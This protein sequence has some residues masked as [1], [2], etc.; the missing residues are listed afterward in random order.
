MDGNGRWSK[1]N[2]CRNRWDGHRY[3]LNAVRDVIKG[4]VEKGIDT[5]T[6]FAFSKENH[7]RSNLEIDALISLFKECLIKETD[8]LIKNGV[9][10]NFVGDIKELSQELDLLANQAKEST[11]YCKK[12]NLNLAI[13]YSGQWQ[14]KKALEHIVKK[15]QKEI[16]SIDDID[17]KT[18]SNII[19][20]D[21]GSEPDLMIR[22]GGEYRISN[23]ILWQL[24][25]TELYFDDKL[26]PDFNKYD[27]Y[28]AIQS[29]AKRQRRFGLEKTHEQFT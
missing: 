18:I 17:E 24:A 9:K 16:M 25:Y 5:L 3:G 7:N 21:F 10:L 22:T 1:E 29:F 13:N 6:L 14:I 15:C 26:W 4:S 12:L 19:N 20:Q 28:Q 23:F 2:H 27:L 8:Q 11:K